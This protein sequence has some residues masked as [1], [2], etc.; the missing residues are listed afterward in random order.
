[1][2]MV[3]L[4]GKVESSTK[5]DDK[6]TREKS[7]T[8][9]WPFEQRDRQSLFLSI[10]RALGGGGTTTLVLGGRPTASTND[11]PLTAS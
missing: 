6:A 1:M 3:S 4:Q 9:V 2:K 11:H 5:L 10:Q 8:L 7:E